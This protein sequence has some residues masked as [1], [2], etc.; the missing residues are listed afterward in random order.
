MAAYS[1]STSPT[2]PLSQTRSGLVARTRAS[3]R[4]RALG[5]AAFCKV[6]NLKTYATAAKLSG[7]SACRAPVS[8]QARA[9]SVPSDDG[10]R[11]TG[12][13]SKGN[14]ADADRARELRKG[15][16]RE[17]PLVESV[18]H[19]GMPPST[20]PFANASL[21][22]TEGHGNDVRYS[23]IVMSGKAR[24]TTAADFRADLKN[25]R[26]PYHRNHPPMTAPRWEA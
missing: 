8:L 18:H 4:G 25:G 23:A 14:P 22:D 13:T 19:G 5:E 9:T 3:C 2:R 26:R 1:T 12:H 20:R 21:K 24:R 10:S 17:Q 16:R 6:R 15:V 11:E 7:L